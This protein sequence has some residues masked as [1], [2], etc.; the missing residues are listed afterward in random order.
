[1]PSALHI[2]QLQLNGAGGGTLA[3]KMPCAPY[4]LTLQ[5]DQLAAA[6]MPTYKISCLPLQARCHD[7]EG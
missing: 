3:C 1:M 2:L 7:C 4:R 5:V 6:W